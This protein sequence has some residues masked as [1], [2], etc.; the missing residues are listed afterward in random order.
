MDNIAILVPSIKS[1]GA[2]KQA[3]L[4]AQCLSEYYS[5][6]F[7]IIY[8]EA[9]F[10]ET[11]AQIL[12]KGINL[13]KHKLE[14]G[15]LSKLRSLYKIFKN[16]HIRIAF[17]YL[18]YCDVYG[19]L[20]EKLSGVRYVYNGIRNSRL[21]QGKLILERFIHNHFATGTIFN[22]FSGS[23]FFQSQGFKSD[24]CVVIP[25]CFPAISSPINRPQK[26]I[27]R[28]ITV[29]RF[30]EQKDYL[31]A[32]KAVSLLK[33]R[34]SSFVYYIVGYGELEEQIYHWIQEYDIEDVSDVFINPSNTQELLSA[35]DIYLST[36]LF[37][38]TSNSI[39]EALNWS[40]PVVAT[41]VG[42][43]YHLISEGYNGFLHSTGDASS[44]CSSLETLIKDSRLRNEFGQNGNSLL[45][46]KYSMSLFK[47]RYV[48]LV[49]KIV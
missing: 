43:N 10:S 46:E 21:P 3:V 6:H 23:D 12:E 19:C 30:V 11:N 20:I 5:V 33:Q 48:A 34:V 27:I 26:D 49:E 4:L 18:T 24:K 9:P 45:K 25:N 28:I 31:T 7:I 2:E 40:L 39:M 47:E 35:S 32:I 13:S 1:G 44:L 41:N 29:G 16:Q 8:G 38:G 42:D 15:K 17:N 36:S 37:E 22:C 14:G